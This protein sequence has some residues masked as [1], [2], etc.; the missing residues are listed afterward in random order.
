MDKFFKLVNTDV[1]PSCPEANE[2]LAEDRVMCLQI[3]IKEKCGYYLTYIPDAKS[4]TDAP[5]TLSILVKQRRRWNNGAL[6]AAF[7]VI[8]NSYNMVMGP[9]GIHPWYAKIGMFMFMVYFITM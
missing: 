9:K 2:Y 7:R 5:D 6:F 1:D 8:A 3:Y 4:F